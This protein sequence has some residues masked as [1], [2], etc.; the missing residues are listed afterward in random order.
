MTIPS[1]KMNLDEIY[2][3]VQNDRTYLRQPKYI[4]ICM[5]SSM[6]PV[7]NPGLDPNV[8]NL[9]LSKF[10]FTTV[11]KYFAYLPMAKKH[12]MPFHYYTEM[13]S[14][15]YVTMIG[16]PA[17]SRSW[18]MEQLISE[19]IL[20]MD[21]RDS[22]VICLQQNYALEPLESQLMEHLANFVITPLMRQNGFTYDRVKFLETVVDRQMVNASPNFNKMKEPYFLDEVVFRTFLKD[23]VKR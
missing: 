9:A 4:L 16:A 12:L 18:Y 8:V 15:N 5:L 14:S 22:I 10:T 17:T 23:F 21:Y 1:I 20:P 7:N 11:N 2:I 13:V 19:R 6:V 3:P